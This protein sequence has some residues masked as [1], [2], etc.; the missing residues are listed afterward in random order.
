M[1][2]F[3]A[4]SLILSAAFAPPS[5]VADVP[6]PFDA[7]DPQQYWLLG[8]SNDGM[9]TIYL[10]QMVPVKNTD[11]GTYH[12]YFVVTDEGSRV[13]NW[14]FATQFEIE[15]NCG[16][17]TYAPRGLWHYDVRGQQENVSLQ[18]QD[19]LIFA[20][21]K[22]EGPYAMAAKHLCDGVGMDGLPQ[23]NRVKVSQLILYQAGK[24]DAAGHKGNYGNGL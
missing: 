17:R 9:E 18:G 8:E 11:D 4:A 3:L 7:T 24:Y 13:E 2:G 20:P 5:G 19:V 22:P 10:R 1:T 16:N 15:F 12:A 21:V 6:D 23:T 14:Q